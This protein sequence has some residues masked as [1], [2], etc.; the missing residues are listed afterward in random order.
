MNNL[1]DTDNY[2]DQEPGELVAGNRWAWTRSDI[3]AT[4]PTALYTLKY[5]LAVMDDSEAVWE[6]TA[7]KTDSAHVVEV[8]Q[9]STG[10]YAVGEYRWQ[11]VVVRDSDSE[12]ITVDSGLV[13]I[14][15]DLGKDAAQAASWT[16]Q[17]LSAIQATLYGA[18]SDKQRSLE[19][20]GRSL[21]S[22]SYS[23]LLGLESEFRKRWQRE[24]AE[25]ERKGGRSTGR[26][27][28]VKMSA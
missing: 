28:L 6:I 25:I 10:G 7:G 24:K 13:S 1:F 2:P 11:A 27:T 3:T 5:R 21:S 4:Y 22:R 14:I 26:R 23:E 9:A 17:V 18:A 15:A 8:S 16:Y 12:E 19:I 20:N